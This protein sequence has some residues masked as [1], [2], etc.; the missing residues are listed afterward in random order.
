MNKIKLKNLVELAIF[1]V[2]IFS[3][4]TNRINIISKEATE[5]K[6]DLGT[7]KKAIETFISGG[8]PYSETVESYADLKSN[9]GDKGFAYPPFLLYL[10]APFHAVHLYFQSNYPHG[11]YFTERFYFDLVGFLADIGTGV[12][13]YLIMR[14]LKVS[15]LA[16]LFGLFVWFFNP[17]IY[18]SNDYYP[19]DLV[20]VF[21][22]TLA[23]YFSGIKKDQVLSGFFLGLASATKTYP[24]LLFPIM[25]YF[26]SPNTAEINSLNSLIRYSYTKLKGSRYFLISFALSLFLL[27]LSFMSSFDNF[28]TFIHGSLLVQS[29]RF[30]QGR[31]FLYYI[32][33]FYKVE[34]LR[35]V[36]FNVYTTLAAVSGIIISFVLAVLSNGRQYLKRV[37]NVFSLSAII[38]AFFY[39]F[40]PVLNRTYLIWI[41][42]SLCV[43]F[44]NLFQHK[45]LVFGYMAVT[46][47][48][49]FYYFYLLPWKDGFHIW[50]P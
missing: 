37:C 6:G 15:K 14:G 43:A 13:I 7:Y 30:V 11:Y 47:F 12:L 21:L 10:Y 50:H 5:S 42:P 32:S 40:T 8:N 22:T 31:P 16:I 23:L 45:K 9:P 2:L 26:S 27:S 19:N 4:L 3:F 39:L 1:C 17:Y 24:I 36:P 44:F 20:V 48:W 38:L 25:L 33:Y 18:K 35:M 46:A 29:E 28:L 41:I 49:L 34:F